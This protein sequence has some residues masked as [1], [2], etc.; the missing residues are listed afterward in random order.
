MQHSSL[1]GYTRCQLGRSNVVL[2]LTYNH[3]SVFLQALV[4]GLLDGMYDHSHSLRGD[5]EL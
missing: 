2:S 5:Y 4:Q 3:L 1:M